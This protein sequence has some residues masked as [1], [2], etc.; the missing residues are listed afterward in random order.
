MIVEAETLLILIDANLPKFC[1][2]VL[3][4]FR[5]WR[6]GIISCYCDYNCDRNN[7][8]SLF[9]ENFRIVIFTKK[10]NIFKNFDSLFLVCKK[11][12][13]LLKLLI[14]KFGLKQII[15]TKY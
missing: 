12:K 15:K 7:K 1:F 5:F 10:S 3:C 11:S 2:S 9:T 6:Y 13:V 8:I 14:S 4:Y